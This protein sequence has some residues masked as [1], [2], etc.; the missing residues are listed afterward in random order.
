[1]VRARGRVGAGG[2]APITAPGRGPALLHVGWKSGPVAGERFPWSVPAVRTLEALDLAVPVTFFVGENGSG[3]STLLEAIAIAARLRAVGTERD[4][5][6]DPS[7]AEQAALAR[8]LR[9][10]WAWK[11]AFGFFLRAEDFFGHLRAQ[12]RLDARLVRERGGA[13]PGADDDEDGYDPVRDDHAHPDEVAARGQ[14]GRYDNRSHGESFL[15]YFAAQLDAPGLYLLDEP[16]T[17]LS[18]QR[19]LTLLAMLADAA[20]G[21]AQ[22]VVATHSPILLAL[23]GAR[24][25]AFDEGGVRETPYNE[26]EHVRVTREFLNVPERFL[27]HLT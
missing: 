24:I 8:E 9:L 20:R 14:L 3:K 23:P 22:L 5:W 19:Q 26:L 4:L 25:Y 11:P 2:T 10:A 7:L 27:K 12:A 21:G 16:E 1:M 18:P 15:D 17:P 13:L 6:R